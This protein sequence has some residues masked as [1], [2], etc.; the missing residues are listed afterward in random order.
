MESTGKENEIR[1]HEQDAVGQEEDERQG[2]REQEALQQPGPG[3]YCER[4]E[5]GEGDL[6]DAE[7]SPHE[8]SLRVYNEDS[9]GMH[10]HEKSPGVHEPNGPGEIEKLDSPEEEHMKNLQQKLT[11]VLNP[12]V[13]PEFLSIFFK[14][15][16]R[17]FSGV[18]SSGTSLRIRTSVAQFQTV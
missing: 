2:D 1:T 3:E 12:F 15:S 10:G 18:N 8:N 9:P 17:T 11:V 5:I 16:M 14:G 6:D 4:E 7:N 13:L